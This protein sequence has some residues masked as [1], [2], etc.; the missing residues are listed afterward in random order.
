M[1]LV[2]L[3][4]TVLF[5]TMFYT[6]LA[7]DVP[8]SRVIARAAKVS[9]T[10]LPSE[11]DLV[12]LVR[13]IENPHTSWSTSTPACE[14]DGVSCNKEAEITG[15]NWPSR[16]LTGELSFSYLPKTLHTLYAYVNKL[17]G[18]LQFDTFPVTCMMRT[19]SL[20][21]NELS[22]PLDLTALPPKLKTLILSGNQ[23]TGDVCL[24]KLPS[25]YDYH[26]VN[27]RD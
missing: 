16:K 24:T 18:E 23:F 11:Y 14:W 8:E 6:F 4:L 19:L 27:C 2:C 15:I 13:N 5:Y 20:R 22:G 3:E 10:N 25:C 9:A 17:S 7:A 26:A 12:R 1:K 21:D